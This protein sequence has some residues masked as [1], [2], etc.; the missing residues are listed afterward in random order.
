MSWK[1]LRYSAGVT[2]PGVPAV[3][4]RLV[5]QRY[6]YIWLFLAIGQFRLGK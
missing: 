1:V 6:Y 2:L 4:V 5:M 3:P